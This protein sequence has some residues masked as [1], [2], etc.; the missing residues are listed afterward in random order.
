MNCAPM[1]PIASE[2]VRRGFNEYLTAVHCPPHTPIAPE[3]RSHGRHKEGGA[4]CLFGS[5]DY[6]IYT[7]SCGLGTIKRVFST[8]NF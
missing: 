1:L 8:V 3:L 5:C 4:E 7:V 6:K 2:R